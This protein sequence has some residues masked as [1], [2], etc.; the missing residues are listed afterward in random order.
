VGWTEQLLTGIAQHFASGGVGTWKASGAYTSVDRRPIVISAV[1]S[2]PDE[3]ITLTAYPVDDDP[4]MSDVLQGVQ[5][6]TRGDRDP[7]TVD[8]LDDDV[9]DA[10]HGLAGV[11]LNGVHVVLAR[12]ISGSPLGVD[13]NGRHQRSS[14]YYMQAAR[15]SPHRTD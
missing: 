1:P 3:V 9:F 5:V 6:R 13:S 11:V 15:P 14:N 8:A 2:S 10:L 4:A 7:R 12:R